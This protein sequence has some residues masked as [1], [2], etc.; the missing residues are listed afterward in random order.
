MLYMARYPE[1]Q[2][3]VQKELDLVVGHESRGEYF[4]SVGVKQLQVI[5]FSSCRNI[6]FGVFCAEIFI[7]WCIM[8]PEAMEN[9]AK[10]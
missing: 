5:F 2:I 6:Q 4:Y 3:K 10:Q 7:L 9:E 8:L 1:V